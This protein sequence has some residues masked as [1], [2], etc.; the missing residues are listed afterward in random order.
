VYAPARVISS[1]E[2]KA[3]ETGQI[4]AE[5]L[6]LPFSEGDDL[7]EHAR[8][9]EQYSSTATFHTNIRGFFI[10]PDKLVYGLETANAA[11]DRF[12]GAV[13]RILSEYQGE[14]VVVV[15]HGTVIT[16]FISRRTGLEPFTLWNSLGLPSFMVFD[17]QIA[18]VVASVHDIP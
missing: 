16:L 6:G 8:Q 5:I 13:D 11:Y 14:T 3:S 12:S 15:A 18:Q 17:T 10:Q 7:H 2:A 4:V 1:K 9:N